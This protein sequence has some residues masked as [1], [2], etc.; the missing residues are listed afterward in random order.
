MKKILIA[1]DD[2]DLLKLY[3]IALNNAAF[4]VDVCLTISEANIFVKSK[5]YDLIILDILF[6][7]GDI[8]PTIQ[9]IRNKSSPNFQTP[10]LILTS[11]S[12]GDKTKKSLEIGA[13]EYLFKATETP[14][15]IV[16]KVIKI[17]SNN[18]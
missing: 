6:P 14:K 8:L 13:N 15:T 7:E 10:I 1:D 12:Y 11:L 18:S 3:K 5:K 2:S 9:T 17:T 16:S 4:E